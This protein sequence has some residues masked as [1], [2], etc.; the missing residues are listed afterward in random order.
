[1]AELILVQKPEQT[2]KVFARAP[3]H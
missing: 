3:A 2:L 1:M